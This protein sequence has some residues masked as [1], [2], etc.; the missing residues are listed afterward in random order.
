MRDLS[1]TSFALLAHL[2]VQPWSAYDLT[3][4]MTRGFDLVWPRATSGL[5]AEI[6]HLEGRGAI[7]AKIEPQG[8]RSRT[9]YSITPQGRR[10]LRA[11]LATPPG[12][13]RLESE[14]L[15]RV[16]FAEE[17]TVDDLREAIDAA[18]AHATAIRER[19]VRQIAGYLSDGG[20]FPERWH[21]IGLGARALLEQAAAW[22]RWANRARQET[23]GWTSV[24]GAAER[25]GSTMLAEL[26]KEFDPTTRGDRRPR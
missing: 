26:F 21:L 7:A 2:A 6:R 11:W 14:V 20:P 10:A 9:V 22:E 15:I 1:T 23:A 12:S 17:G 24:H 13:S 8:R 5:Y 19:L 16:F 4:Q 18:A 3:N 25:S